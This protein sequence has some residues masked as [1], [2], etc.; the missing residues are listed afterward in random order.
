MFREVLRREREAGGT[1]WLRPGAVPTLTQILAHEDAPL[2][3]VLIELLDEIP[4]T[5]AVEAL[6]R[7]AVFDL[8]ADNREAAVAALRR[9]PAAEYRDVLLSGLR[10]PWPP[11]AEH[12]AEALAALGDVRA[13]PDLIG[14]LDEPDPGL[15]RPGEDKRLHVREP[16]R[17]RHED[18]CLACHPAAVTSGREPVSGIIPGLTITTLKSGSNRGA[19][20]GKY[21]GPPPTSG[22]VVVDRRPVYVRADLTFLR[23]E[24]SVQLPEM[25]PGTTLPA[26]ARYDYLVRTRAV[27]PR[28]A[29]QIRARRQEKRV[30][31]AR[32]A[33]LFALREL[34][35]EV[36][37]TADAWKEWWQKRGAE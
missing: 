20:K 33:V 27:S 30:P 13:V 29:E 8:S 12:A 17:V 3:H 16:V 14:L 37:E 4:G 18:N 23:Q 24:F 11:A 32:D 21:G 7:R 10:H 5:P 26:R 36:H 35:G 34:T 15:P 28:E 9:R 2:R 1:D 22:V 19:G 31:P 6:A 25:R